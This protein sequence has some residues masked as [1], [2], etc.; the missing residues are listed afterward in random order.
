MKNI[1]ATVL[2]VTSIGLF[3]MFIDPTWTDIGA[4]KL[5]KA[6]FD[7]A[8]NNTEKVKG[9]RDE[10]LTKYNSFSADNRRKLE[11]LLPS[12]VDNVRLIIEI[13]NIALRHNLVLN[14]VQVSQAAA[15]QS[16]TGVPGDTSLY[17]TVPISFSASGS[18]DGFLSFLSDLEHDLRVL[19]ITGLNVK[20][21]ADG[22]YQ[23][24][25]QINTYWLKPVESAQII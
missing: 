3:K 17:G 24:S 9:I 21:G 16:N 23:Y 19:D 8:L 20:V 5:Q 1:I 18:Y 22:D 12:N 4:L 13:N 6:D 14:N 10:L 11:K 7:E 15:I 2:I 25:F